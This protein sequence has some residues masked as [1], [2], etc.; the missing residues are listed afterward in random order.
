MLK[1]SIG[2]RV[3]FTPQGRPPV[4]G[5]IVKYNRKTV[6][7]VAED[8]HQWNVHPG[9]LSHSNVVDAVTTPPSVI[10]RQQT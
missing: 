6:T 2:D 4:F 7:V 8:G 9:L 10:A 1:F 3:A 5:V